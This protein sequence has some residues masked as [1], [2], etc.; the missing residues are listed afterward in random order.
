[1]KKRSI[2]LSAAE[3]IR[4]G[5]HSE[6][7]LK[8]LMGRR[9][10]IFNPPFWGIHHVFI[11]AGLTHTVVCLKSDGS[12]Y[13]LTGNSERPLKLSCYGSKGEIIEETPLAEG[14]MQWNF[15][16]DYAIYRGPF[17]P[18]TNEP[19]HWGKVIEIKEFDGFISP[20]RIR[21]EIGSLKDEY[22]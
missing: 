15:Y 22:R 20:D 5:V 14:K 19:Y 8:L 16:R 4:R 7:N 1:M 6:E 21:K 17:L 13:V 10:T 2:P 12:T 11:D 9:L 3:I 18:P